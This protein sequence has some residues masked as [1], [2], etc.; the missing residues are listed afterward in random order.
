MFWKFYGAKEARKPHLVA[1]TQQ[2][3]SQHI[4]CHECRAF[5]PICQAAKLW[6]CDINATTVG[7]SKVETCFLIK[8]TQKQT[9]RAFRANNIRRNTL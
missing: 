1:D 5:L 4:L 6:N 2:K 9:V 8:D 7:L 3:L